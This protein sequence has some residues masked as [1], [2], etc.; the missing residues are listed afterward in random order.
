MNRIVIPLLLCL[1]LA[2]TVQ[3]AVAAKMSHKEYS[4]LELKYCNDCHKDQGI[5]LT[6]DNDWA[7]KHHQSTDWMAEHRAVASKAGTNCTD[8]HNQGF[9]LSVTPGPAVTSNCAS[10]T[11]GVI[12]YPRATAATLSRAAAQIAVLDTLNAEAARG[13]A[14]LAVTP[15]QMP[16]C[17]II[18]D[19]VR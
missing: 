16:L 11:S 1:L 5:A 3:F 9:C 15:A 2:F 17:L 12:T 7:G 8:C 14:R 13:G 6:H 18:K 10:R 4:D 19:M